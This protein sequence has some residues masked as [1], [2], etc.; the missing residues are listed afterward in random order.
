MDFAVARPGQGGNRGHSGH[1]GHHPHFAGRVVI[2]A[3]PFYA[4]PRYYY[5]PPHY[6]YPPPAYYPPEPPVY[7]EQGAPP[8]YPVPPQYQPPQPQPQGQY[9]PDGQAYWYYCAAVRGYY[10][11]VKVCPGGWQ[12]VPQ[13]PPPG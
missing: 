8:S 10:P 11:H 4:V 13:T 6:Y 7:I 1:G 12:K 3:A 5:P 2:F 9:Q